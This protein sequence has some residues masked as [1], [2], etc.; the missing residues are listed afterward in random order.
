[1]NFIDLPNC[2]TGYLNLSLLESILV[3]VFTPSDQHNLIPSL[4]FTCS[5]TVSK[6][7]V[8]GLKISSINDE[9]PLNF[10]ISL[11]QIEFRSSGSVS[12]S[13]IQLIEEVGIREISPTDKPNVYTLTTSNALRFALGNF[14][15]ISQSSSSPLSL[16]YVSLNGGNHV[17]YVYSNTT[18]SLS[19]IQLSNANRRIVALPLLRPLE[20]GKKLKKFF[21]I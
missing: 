12:G 8:G 19:N 20:L 9:N 13:R 17:N 16:Y 5:G 11:W 18:T 15:G 21:S 7:T 3:E 6:W 4:N 10:K 2:T 1:M 14:I